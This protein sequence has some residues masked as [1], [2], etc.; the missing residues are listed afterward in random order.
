MPFSGDTLDLATFWRQWLAYRAPMA[1][2]AYAFHQALAN[3][4][5]D[6]AKAFAQQHRV[7][8]VALAGGVLHNRLL[9]SLLVERLEGLR[10]IYPERL[11]MGDGGLAFGQAI[12][13]ASRN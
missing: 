1:D 11:P 13:A 4:M 12:V 10:V 3:G 9:R 2:R 5:G 7:S 8:T 6:M